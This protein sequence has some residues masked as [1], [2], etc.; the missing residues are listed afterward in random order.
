MIIQSVWTVWTQSCN[1][2]LWTSLTNKILKTAALQLKLLVLNADKR[3]LTEFNRTNLKKK[4]GVLVQNIGNASNQCC[5]KFQ[6]HL[7]IVTSFLWAKKVTNI[8]NIGLGR[9]VNA[10][11]NPREAV[12]TKGTITCTYWVLQVRS[13]FPRAPYSRSW[14]PSSADPLFHC[15][16]CCRTKTVL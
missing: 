12:V 7:S 14:P 5:T 8:E 1:K 3:L 2:N 6:T 15:T 13:F 11:L 10:N 16:F 9:W 4:V